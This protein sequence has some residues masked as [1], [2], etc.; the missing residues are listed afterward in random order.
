MVYQNN[1]VA[2]AAHSYL[3]NN[4][5]NSADA[6]RIFLSEYKSLLSENAQL[7][8]EN[9]RLRTALEESEDN[10][11]LNYFLPRERNK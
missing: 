4:I 10:S 7:K 11:M 8:Q 9:A 3:T 6:M 2:A 1:T 5:E